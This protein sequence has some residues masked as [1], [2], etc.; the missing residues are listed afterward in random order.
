M[1][2][3]TNAARAMLAATMVASALTLL[4]MATVAAEQ[5]QKYQLDT[6]LYND[7]R[8]GEVDGVM[9]ITVYTSG[10]VKGLYR[11]TGGVV[12]DVSGGV[13]G[14]A[15]WLDVAQLGAG[16]GNA[17]GGLHITGTFKDGVLEATA[18]PHTP[19]TAVVQRGGTRI[20]ES[21]R[22]VKLSD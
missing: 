2:A 16:P 14:N 9:T 1:R 20:F 3:M 15:I 17:N 7:N 21:T 10:I 18:S 4:P 11:P 8:A 6:R 22:T 5:Q 12:R 19:G 13:K